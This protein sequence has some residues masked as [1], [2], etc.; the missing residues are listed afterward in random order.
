MFTRES[1]LTVM[2]VLPE[3]NEAP[4]V[5]KDLCSFIIGSHQDPTI[6]TCSETQSKLVSSNNK[7][8][9]FYPNQH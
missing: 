2:S 4:K 1:S 8:K 3:S 9:F 6:L 7:A 5:S